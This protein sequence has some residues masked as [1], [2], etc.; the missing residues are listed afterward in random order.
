[1]A[2]AMI[3]ATKLFPATERRPTARTLQLPTKSQLAI[4][5]GDLRFVG[6]SS[7]SAALAFTSKVFLGV[8]VPKLEAVELVAIILH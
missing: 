4:K 2:A 1:M 7:C 6:F 3:Y 5:L 8:L